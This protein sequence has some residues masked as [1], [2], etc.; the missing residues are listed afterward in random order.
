[1][2][3]ASV[4]PGQKFG[5]LIK[6]IGVLAGLAGAVLLGL[7]CLWWFE[8]GYWSPK[9]PLDL[10]LWLGLSYTPVAWHGLEHVLLWLLGLPLAG[11]L[12]ALAYL[13]FTLGRRIEFWRG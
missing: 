6:A 2:R 9:T 4:T 7:Q 11:V 12:L 5:R 8:D 3:A 1:M 10:W 13:V